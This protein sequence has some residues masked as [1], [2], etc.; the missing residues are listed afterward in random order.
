MMVQG[1]DCITTSLFCTEGIQESE[2]E[3]NT[4]SFNGE[5]QED[6]RR[7][8]V[9]SYMLPID[10]DEVIALLIQ[11]ENDLRSQ[12]EEYIDSYGGRDVEMRLRTQMVS[13]MLDVHAYFG[14]NSVTAVLSVGY[15]DRF[16]SKHIDSRGKTWLLQLVAVAC[17]SLAAKLEESEVPLLL[18]LQ[19]GEVQH[20]FESCTIQR[21]ELL[22]L[23]TLNWQLSSATP[24]SYLHYLLH[25]IDF[26]DGSP[27]ALIARAEELILYTCRDLRFL[28]Y[29]P[30]VV[31]V[32]SLICA[33]EEEVPLQ[34]ACLKRALLSLWPVKE[35]K[36]TECAQLMEEM[37]RADPFWTSTLN[38]VVSRNSSAPQSPMGVLDAACFSSES[39]DRTHTTTSTTCFASASVHMRS[40]TIT[41]SIAHLTPTPIA[42]TKCADLS[43]L[44]PHP[45]SKKRKLSEQHKMPPY[46]VSTVR[47]H[48]H[49][50]DCL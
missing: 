35:I 13:W 4:G 8:D 12:I 24:F 31:A 26:L 32:A 18:D 28:A 46:H 10:D 2:W 6:A 49:N 40:S 47:D 9:C 11:K 15:F 5:L 41:R 16:L 39:C 33:C 30:S 44:P 27:R 34:A 20:V 43:T 36:V 29:S 21:M 3:D 1:F 48:G 23:S 22:I 17:I 50:S 25:K 37:L 14:F 19:V 42:S 38:K 7:G 45:S